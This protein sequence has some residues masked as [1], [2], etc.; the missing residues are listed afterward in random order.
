MPEDKLNT[1]NITFAIIVVALLFVL[2]HLYIIW[3]KK[4]KD[5]KSKSERYTIRQLDRPGSAY[6]KNLYADPLTGRA[7][8]DL[9]AN[10]PLPGTTF[11]IKYDLSCS[12]FSPLSLLFNRLKENIESSTI[13]FVSKY[14]DPCD[15][16][17]NY[18]SFPVI[19]KT[20]IDYTAGGSNGA[21]EGVRRMSRYNGSFDYGEL[22][23]YVLNGNKCDWDEFSE[24]EKGKCMMTV[25]DKGGVVGRDGCGLE[26][27]RS[28]GGNSSNVFLTPYESDLVWIDK[29]SKLPNKDID[30]LKSRDNFPTTVLDPSNQVNNHM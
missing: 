21:N 3:E 7:I 12:L 19:F 9:W 28:C 25:E 1:D 24:V 17:L 10:Q 11:V 8:D 22:Q 26:R 30:I 5:G 23:D 18:D 6:G 29:V 15:Q 13:V 4:C 20:W 14:Y 16:I 27:Q 2:Y